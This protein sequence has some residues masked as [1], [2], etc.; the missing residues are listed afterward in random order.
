MLFCVGDYYHQFQVP[1]KKQK[2]KPRNKQAR[3]LTGLLFFFFFFFWHSVEC[4]HFI[5][6]NTVH[7]TYTCIVCHIL[8][9][10]CVASTRSLTQK[11]TSS[12]NTLYI[13][14]TNFQLHASHASRVCTSGNF[15][16][17][18]WVATFRGLQLKTCGA[19]QNPEFPR[20]RPYW[21]GPKPVRGRGT[22]LRIFLG[23]VGSGRGVLFRVGLGRGILFRV[24]VFFT[25]IW[26]IFSR[27][28]GHKLTFHSQTEEVDWLLS[29]R[30]MLF[31][32]ITSLQDIF[33]CLL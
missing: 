23:R 27:D 7:V 8:I 19:T 32:V 25:R 28:F 33:T 18:D 26:D 1:Q 30:S 9:A 13:L 12:I 3:E 6:L 22:F 29:L 4:N 2:T 20:T 31:D 21:T 5:F 15:Q 24:G 16:H 11:L 14:T 10:S 17:A